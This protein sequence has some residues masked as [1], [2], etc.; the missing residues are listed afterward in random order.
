M[1]TPRFLKLCSIFSQTSAGFSFISAGC[2]LKTGYFDFRAAYSLEMMCASCNKYL[3]IAQ[4]FSNVTR[5]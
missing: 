4:A 1:N 3:R 5:A 2:R